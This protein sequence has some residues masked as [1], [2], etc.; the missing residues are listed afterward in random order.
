M[1]LVCWSVGRKNSTSI[2]KKH[3]FIMSKERYFVWLPCKRYV[4]AWLVRKF[5]AG[6]RKWPDGVNISAEKTLMSLIKDKLRRPSMRYENRMKDYSYP[7]RVPIEISEDTFYRYGWEL[8]PTDINDINSRLEHIIKDE[9]LRYLEISV[10][11]TGN[12]KRS[13]R[14]FYEFSGFKEA[15]WPEESIRRYFYRH[16]MAP[17]IQ[18][19]IVEQKINEIFMVTLSHN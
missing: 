12:I 18:T 15:E 14:A 6:D 13:I 17:V 1:L 11:F 8:S 5:S 2:T 9:L 3:F 4:K 7:E 10:A 19:N 16:R